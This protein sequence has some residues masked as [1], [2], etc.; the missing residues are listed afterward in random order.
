MGH[1]LIRRLAGAF[2]VLVQNIKDRSVFSAIRTAWNDPGALAHLR[3]PVV[4]R[5]NRA[6]MPLRK[7]TGAD[8]DL[9]AIDG[10]TRSP[11][12]IEP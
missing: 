3:M 7:L 1:F 5:L 11:Q 6:M 2:L 9:P 8:T 12:R 10:T 4:A